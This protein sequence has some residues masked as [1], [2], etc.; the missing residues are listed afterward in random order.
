MVTIKDIADRAGVSFSTVSKALRDS[1][2]VQDKTKQHILS[3]AKEMGYQPNIAA[4]SLVSRKSGAIGVVWP[5]IERA[6]LSSLLTRVNEEL[7]KQGYITLLSISHMESAVEIFRRY[8]VDAILVFG[9]KDSMTGYPHVNPPQIPILTYGT[10]GHTAHSAVDVNRGQAIR[11]AVRH[12]VGLGHQHI[13][14]IGEPDR[15]DPLQTVKIEAFR[16]EILQLGLNYDPDSVLQLNGLEFHDGYMAARTMLERTVRPT[17]VISG[18]IDLTR[19]ML[20]AISEHGLRVPEDISIV[21]YDNL[22][23][24]EDIGVPMT[25]VGAAIST[26]SEVIASTIFELIES[27]ESLKTV[28]LEPELVVRASTSKLQG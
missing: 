9:D 17:A 16:E 25:V 19:G 18:G 4:R 12:L 7:E 1:P 13:A 22:P 10:A 14:Y 20:R 5:S 28:F 11:L 2:L 27:P 26:I 15:P 8:Q 21:S 24:M 6:A 23:Q 3:I